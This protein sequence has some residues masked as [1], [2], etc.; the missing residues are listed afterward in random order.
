MYFNNINAGPSQTTPLK[1]KR[2]GGERIGGGGCI[3]L[4]F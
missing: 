3:H 4:C 2:V 1:A